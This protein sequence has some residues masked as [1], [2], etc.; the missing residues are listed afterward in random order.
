MTG[1]ELSVGVLVLA[2]WGALMTLSFEHNTPSNSGASSAS[3]AEGTAFPGD[4]N[5]FEESINIYPRNDLD[6]APLSLRACLV[7][8]CAG[9]ALAGC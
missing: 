4:E 9:T 7:D 3:D 1:K 5:K 2:T 8:G 6:D